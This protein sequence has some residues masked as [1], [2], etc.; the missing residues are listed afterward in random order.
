M[1]MTKF[2]LVAL[3]F[4][5]ALIML[6]AVAW[7]CQILDNRKKA[8]QDVNRKVEWAVRDYISKNFSVVFHSNFTMH[9]YEITPM[10][11]GYH[12]VMLAK[13]LGAGDSLSCTFT[14]GM[15]NGKYK[16]DGCNTKKIDFLRKT[17]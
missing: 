17:V 11:D 16:V 15:Y 13:I 8:E 3:I 1:I 12:V 6:F 9:F 5:M 4:G 14:V 10:D 2:E 7:L